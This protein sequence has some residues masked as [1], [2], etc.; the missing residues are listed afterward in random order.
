MKEIGN[1]QNILDSIGKLRKHFDNADHLISY[2]EADLD[3]DGMYQY[4]D[5]AMYDIKT[6]YNELLQSIDSLEQDIADI[7][8]EDEP[9]LG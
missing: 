2:L 4:V 8:D 6:T 5:S 3:E 1:L 7:I 9:D